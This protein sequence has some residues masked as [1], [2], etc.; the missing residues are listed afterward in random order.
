MA[1]TVT[2]VLEDTL[3]N[4]K[5]Y[6]EGNF[7]S[8]LEAMD[9]LKGSAE[10][11]MDDIKEHIIGD[12][13]AL[14][15]NRYPMAFYYPME[16]SVEALDLGEDEIKMQL[17]FSISLKGADGDKLTIKAL[18]YSD[19]FR[20]MVNGDHTLGGACDYARVSKVNYFSAEPGSGNLMEIETILTV[21]LTVAN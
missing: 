15:N 10:Y 7:S 21:T 4:I 9:T 18:R 13:E 20:E 6:V 3:Y 14:K 5:D 2:S 19:C 17:Y 8:Y 12:L 1:V 11:S 16:I